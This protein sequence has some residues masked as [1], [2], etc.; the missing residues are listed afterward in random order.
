MNMKEISDRLF[1]LR[2][3]KRALADKTKEVQNEM[4]LL[5]EQ[6]ISLMDN[7]NLKNFRSDKAMF[8]IIGDAHCKVTDEFTFHEWLKNNGKEEYIRYNV[9][10]S[11]VKKIAKE[12]NCEVPGVEAYFISKIGMRQ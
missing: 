4:D 3:E 10:P 8:Y 1:L 2:E 6:L 9:Q 5:E 7:D 11:S 12:N